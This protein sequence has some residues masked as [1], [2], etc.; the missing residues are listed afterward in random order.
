MNVVP[1]LALIQRQ[2]ARIHSLEVQVGHY[3]SARNEWKRKAVGRSRENQLLRKKLK[4]RPPVKRARSGKPHHV[5]AEMWRQHDLIA[6]RIR[7]IPNR[8][9]LEKENGL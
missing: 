6:A 3:R 7:S 1:L 8:D 9:I 5:T 2:K 4:Q